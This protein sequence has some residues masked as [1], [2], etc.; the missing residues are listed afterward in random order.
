MAMPE[1]NP[2]K[3]EESK[4]SKWKAIIPVIGCG[5]VAGMFF[6]GFMGLILF[7]SIL[8]AISIENENSKKGKEVYCWSDS[9]RLSPERLDKKLK[10]KGVF[11]GK[12]KVFIDAGE[13]HG[14]DP[15]LVAAIAMHE[16][17]NGTSDEVRDLNNPG[18]LREK[19]GPMS[20]SS[21]DEGIDRMTSNLYRLYIKLGLTTPEKI[22]PKYAPVGAENDPLGL[23]KHWVTG[24]K[25]QMKQ[26]GGATYKCGEAGKSGK[27]KGSSPTAYP[28]R[29]AS[30][31]GVDAW[32]FYNRQCTSFVAWRLNDAGI[33]FHNHMK[34]GRFGNATNWDV[35]ARQIGGIKVN[36]TPAPG[37]VAQW[38]AGNHASQFGHVAYVTEVK[39]D[40]ITIEEYNYKPY[41]FSR[42]T[43]PA[44]QPSY[45]LHFK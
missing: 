3:S 44:S 35:N 30:V 16:T 26:L 1:P 22:G 39:G 2:S 31:T 14:V 13:R 17:G 6:I 29:N 42:R 7:L 10:N 19:N 33:P 8:G 43:L 21:L 25:A 34:G 38:K 27:A 11:K 40:Q 5:A 23:N 12:G 45:Y 32:K 24:I 36:K 28:Y 41:S 15:I 4:K 18:G 9:K 20:F 37:A